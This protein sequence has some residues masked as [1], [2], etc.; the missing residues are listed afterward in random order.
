[1]TNSNFSYRLGWLPDWPDFRDKTEADDQISPRLF[2]LGQTD[3]IKTMKSRITSTKSDL[4][5]L[6]VSVN[7]TQWFSPAKDQGELG[8]CTANAAVSLIEYFEYRAFGK[9]TEPS[10]L[11]LYKTA[12][13]L[14]HQA[15]D[16]GTFLRN[17]MGAMVLFGAPPEE[18]WPYTISEFDKEPTPF[19]YAFA[20]NYQA[21][22]YYRL[23][24]SGISPSNLLASI[25]K[26]LAGN[27]PLMFGFSVYNS[28][29]QANS[30]GGKIPFPERGDKLE[31]GH[32]VV[33]AGYDD[34]ISIKHTNAN[35]KETTGA[36]LIK[37]SWG[38]EWG[39]NGYGWIPY[40]Y[41]LKGMATDW[42]SLLKNEWVDTGNFQD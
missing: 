17:M 26:S 2:G 41:I 30:N 5:T 12:R 25:K 7:L 20:Q 24:P 29:S 21:I 32:A 9:F 23:D 13:N 35:S 15:G 3:S 18:Y 22:S 14:L 1:M 36:I 34:R 38:T 28:I 33:A 16:S 42:W 31:G 39:D 37:N 8:S 10:R 4:E 6:P 11:F 40:E 19:C 27:L